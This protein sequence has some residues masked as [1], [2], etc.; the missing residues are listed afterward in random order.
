[1]RKGLSLFV[2]TNQDL[3]PVLS[4]GIDTQTPAAKNKEWV[5]R[6]VTQQHQLQPVQTCSQSI[7]EATNYGA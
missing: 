6:L 5:I 1:M 7:Q 3:S 2:E 4:R